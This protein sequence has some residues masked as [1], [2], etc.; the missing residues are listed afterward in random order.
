MVAQAR[1]LAPLAALIEEFR[2][3][4]RDKIN[5]YLERSRNHLLELEKTRDKMKTGQ[6]TEAQVGEL[7]AKFSHYEEE[8][9]AKYEFSPEPPLSEP[10]DK[11][12]NLLDLAITEE[13]TEIYSNERGVSEI[14]FFRHTLRYG[15]VISVFAFLEHRL[16]GICEK[17]ALK[18]GGTILPYSKLGKDRRGPVGVAETYFKYVLELKWPQT[19][20]ELNQLDL[21][22]E[23]RNVI[24]HNDGQL[25][26]EPEQINKFKKEIGLETDEEGR[27][28]VTTEYCEGIAQSLAGFLKKLGADN[29]DKL[30]SLLYDDS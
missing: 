4:E 26:G 28:H 25:R 24:V 21:L 29:G 12:A 11:L 22:H 2:S 5:E 17:A 19:S 10:V 18:R 8:A 1:G 30:F 7:I 20:P 16:R 3:A 14:D 27:V 23:L 9:E 6:L 13:H 15:F